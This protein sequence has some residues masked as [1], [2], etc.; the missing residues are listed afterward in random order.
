MT[1]PKPNPDEAWAAEKVALLL[2]LI[3]SRSA[4]VLSWMADLDELG[5]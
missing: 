5:D 1:N 4:V 3:Q 2:A